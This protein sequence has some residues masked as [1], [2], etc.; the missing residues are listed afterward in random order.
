MSSGNRAGPGGVDP[1]MRLP[2]LLSV[3]FL[4]GG[5]VSAPAP[6]RIAAFP[7]EPSRWATWPWPNAEKMDAYKGITRYRTVTDDGTE[8]ELFQVDFKINPK[9]RFRM[10][11]QGRSG[12]EGDG[13]RVDYYDKGVGQV[14]RELG[15]KQTVALAWNGLFFAYDRSPGSPPHGWARHIGPDVIDGHV[16]YNVGNARWAFGVKY[17]TPKS[18]ESGPRPAFKTIHM[19]DKDVL[20][21]ELDYGSVGAQCLVREGKPLRLQPIPGPDDPPLKQ[22]VPST[23][24]EA[25]HI[26]WVDHIRTSR[27]SIGW[28]KDSQ[29]LYILIVSEPNTEVA[30]KVAVRM[31]KPSDGGWTLAD[32]K[33]FWL[34][35]GVWGAVNSDGGIVTQRAWL[36]P[37][38]KYD[39]LTPQT[40]GAARHIVVGPDLNGAPAGGTLLTF[41][42]AEEPSKK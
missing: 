29:T 36:R 12:E 3:G 19:A 23:D 30:S 39:L 41:Y 24:E 11:D 27:T 34:K 35:L 10:Y 15:E 22:P 18:P 14:V 1:F 2:L 5:C 42:I 4:A 32:L 9:L 13:S 28:S 21:R 26:P 20:G 8:L 25:G 7:T 33:R 40:S 16:A 37:D 6:R 17:S 31:G 38:G